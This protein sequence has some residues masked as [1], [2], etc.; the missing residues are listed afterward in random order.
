MYVVPYMASAAWYAEWLRGLSIGMPE[1]EAVGLAN[2]AADVYGK[3]FARCRIRSNGGEILLS[4]AIEGGSS[5]LRRESALPKVMLSDHGN[6]RHT[7]LGALNAAYGRTPYYQHFMPLL[8]P[9]YQSAEV[10][11]SGFNAKI[12]EAILKMLFGDDDPAQLIRALSGSNAAKER[13]KE[14]SA[15]ISLPLSVIDALMRHGREVLLALYLPKPFL[16]KCE[17]LSP[18]IKI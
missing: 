1:T 18:K 11:L 4:E 16:G 10:S 13:G 12:H 17:G 3:D 9:V 2:C 15:E 14:I 5:R 8:E 7:H 6:W